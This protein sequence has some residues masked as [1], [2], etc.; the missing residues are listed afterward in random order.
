MWQD[1]KSPIR[2]L[3]SFKYTVG[4]SKIINLIRTHKNDISKGIFHSL[5][6]QSLLLA[7]ENRLFTSTEINLRRGPSL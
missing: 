7:F 4:L 5:L 6:H 2:Y 1:F 3:T